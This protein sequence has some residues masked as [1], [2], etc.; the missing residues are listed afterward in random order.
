M[1]MKIVKL[2]AP[3]GCQLVLGQSHFIMSMED[4]AG[5]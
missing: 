4:S 5:F 3:G 2:E 1:E